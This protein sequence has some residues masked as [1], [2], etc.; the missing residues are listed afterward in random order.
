MRHGTAED[1]AHRVVSTTD[2]EMRY[3]RKSHGKRGTRSQCSKQHWWGLR[4]YQPRC[5]LLALPH[6]QLRAQ[7]RSAARQFPPSP[8][9]WSWLVVV[10]VTARLPA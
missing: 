7:P 9:G 10:Y 3:G 1:P 2:R 4:H 8:H 5:D 6:A